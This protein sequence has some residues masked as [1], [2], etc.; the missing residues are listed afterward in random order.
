[1][2]VSV[3]LSAYRRRDQIVITRPTVPFPPWHGSGSG[4]PCCCSVPQSPSLPPFHTYMPYHHH[5]RGRDRRLFSNS[6]SLWV[7]RRRYLSFSSR[8]RQQ[9]RLFLL[10]EFECVG[11]PFPRFLRRSLPQPLEKRIA[12]SSLFNEEMSVRLTLRKG[13]PPRNMKSA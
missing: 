5:H 3:N 6:W 9:Q 2:H 7:G 11:R 4:T 10:L 8:F 1:M 12:V 13:L